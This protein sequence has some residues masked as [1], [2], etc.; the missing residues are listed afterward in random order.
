MTYRLRFDTWQE[1]AKYERTRARFTLLKDGG[2]DALD[3]YLSVPDRVRKEIPKPSDL[4]EKESAKRL[5]EA[6]IRYGVRRLTQAIRDGLL[7]FSEE[8]LFEDVKLELPDVPAV[9]AMMREKTCSFQHRE[10]REL[11]C[12]AAASDDPTAKGVVG[13]STLAPTSGALCIGCDLPDTDFLCS[14]FLSPAVTG[15]VDGKTRSRD[16][17]GGLCDL[18]RKEIDSAPRECRA[19]GHSCWETLVEPMDM[20]QVVPASPLTLPE[21]IDFLDAV[22]RLSFGSPLVRVPAVASAAELS[23][24][25]STLSDFESRVAAL[26]SL[27]GALDVPGPEDSSDHALDRMFVL[28]RERLAEDDLGAVQAALVELEGIVQLNVALQN[29]AKKGKLQRALARLRVPYPTDDWS[30]TWDR[31]RSRCAVALSVIRNAVRTL[32]PVPPADAEGLPEPVEQ[33]RFE[34]PQEIW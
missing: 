12:S 14:H 28:L 21:T 2:G 4:P 26:A 24:P 34:L 6:L 3:V 25:C 27:L 11:L 18:G 10:G 15:Q 32:P 7:P 9:V 13:T 33:P 19:G 17:V 5:E 30:Q 29:K 31:I 1:E 22:W 16:L 20:S 8:S 23:R